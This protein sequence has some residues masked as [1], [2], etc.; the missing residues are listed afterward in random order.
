MAQSLFMAEVR[1]VIR[2]RHMALTTER[3]YCYWIKGFIRYMRYSATEAIRQ[4][5]VAAYL[6]YL[7]VDRHVSPNTQNQ[8]FN[9][10]IFLFRHVL[11]VPIEGVNARRAVEQRRIPVVLNTLYYPNLSSLI[12][13]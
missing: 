7:A 4:E 2:S 13:P 9:A 1:R 5:D 6:S 11:G 3:T 8:A 12:E 10:L